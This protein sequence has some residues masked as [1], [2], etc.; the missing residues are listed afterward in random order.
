MNFLQQNS[1]TDE[2]FLISKNIEYFFFTVSS[3]HD[4]EQSLFFITPKLILDK[5]KN[6]VIDMQHY[7][8]CHAA[9][10]VKPPDHMTD[11]DDIME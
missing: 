8:A 4:R 2:L 9:S 11:D 5:F 3:Q 10:A 6:R 7:A 1:S